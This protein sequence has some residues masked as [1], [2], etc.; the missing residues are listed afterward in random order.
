MAVRKTAIAKRAGAPAVAPLLDDLR[1]LIDAAQARV[2]AAVNAELTVLYWRIGRRINADVLRG[3]RAG[4]AKR[5][6][7]R[8]R[9]N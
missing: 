4:M 1:A 3:R 6:L 5:L 7:R 8:C 9:K 2:A